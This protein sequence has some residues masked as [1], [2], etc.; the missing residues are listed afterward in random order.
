[1][2]VFHVPILPPPPSS[3]TLPLPFILPPYPYPCRPACPVCLSVAAS[4]PRPPRTSPT[5][6][7]M[8]PTCTASTAPPWALAPPYT[9]TRLPMTQQ[10]VRGVQGR[11]MPPSPACLVTCPPLAP[12]SH[13]RAAPC[14]GTPAGRRCRRG[15]RAALCA[16]GRTW[17]CTWRT[18]TADSRLAAAARAGEARRQAGRP[19]CQRCQIRSVCAAG[20]GIVKAERVRRRL[21]GWKMGGGW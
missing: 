19:L 7:C 11:P 5:W 14:A 17:A 13:A 16:P 3:S 15:G 6:A 10:T 1:M 8:W 12:P 21:Q 9:P 18:C 20:R 2:S 4:C